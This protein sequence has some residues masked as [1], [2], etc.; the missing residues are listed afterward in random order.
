MDRETIGYLFSHQYDLKKVSDE[1]KEFVKNN[2]RTVLLL[3]EDEAIRPL[4]VL[5][6]PGLLFT[7]ST[8]VHKYMEKI[9]KP[10]C[11][12]VMF[13]P[14]GYIDKSSIIVVGVAPSFTM[15]CFGESNWLYGQSSRTLHELLN[16]DYKWYFTNCVKEYFFKSL[17]N[18]KMIKESYPDILKEL[19]F[20]SGQRIIFTGDFPIYD[21]LI[22][23]LEIGQYLKI[24]HPS[25]TKYLRT[26]QI[27][28]LKEQIKGF[29]QNG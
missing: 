22:N 14:R 28:E 9:F 5:R 12:N 18:E 11:D 26:K 19:Q 2:K 25:A 10:L 24:T 13:Q 29:V 4:L 15:H 7:N 3:P 23:D 21:R 27:T 20:F 16:F 8:F 6:Y 17:Y 1:E